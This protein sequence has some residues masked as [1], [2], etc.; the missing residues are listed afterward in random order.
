MRVFTIAAMGAAVLAGCAPF[1]HGHYSDDVSFLNSVGDPRGTPLVYQDSPVQSTQFAPTHFAS[2]PSAPAWPLHT[3]TVTSNSFG[4]GGFPVQAA[5]QPV[6]YNQPA[7][8][9][10]PIPVQRITQASV[11][12]PVVSTPISYAPAVQQTYVPPVQTHFVPTVKSVPAPIVQTVVRPSVT[13]I[14]RPQPV[15]QTVQR[16]S[17]V[18]PRQPTG[19]VLATTHGGHQV[20]A[21][22]YAICNIPLPSHVANQTPKFRPTYRPASHVQRSVPQPLLQF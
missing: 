20:D 12:A 13:Q 15:Q 5:P 22:G 2:A 4:A 19:K 11:V 9:S 21:D 6:A 17:Y 8:F 3:S 18:G 14:I 7:Q 1:Q 10:A 16:A